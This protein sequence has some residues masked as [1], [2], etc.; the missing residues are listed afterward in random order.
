MLNCP[1]CHS[2]HVF[3]AICLSCG[4]VVGNPS[5]DVSWSSQARI[6]ATSDS[7]LAESGEDLD[8]DTFVADHYVD[9][10]VS[11]ARSM[12]GGQEPNAA[13]H[14]ATLTGIVVGNEESAEDK[15]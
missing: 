10:D 6:A 5:Y 9:F 7:E 12:I 2:E 15:D 4:H 8:S 1:Q 11:K 3:A 14:S 13:L